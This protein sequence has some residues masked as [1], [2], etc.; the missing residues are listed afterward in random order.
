MNFIKENSMFD[1]GDK[2]IVAF[3]GGPDS[4]CLL[5]ILNELKE[6]WGITLFGAHLNHCLR[7][8]ESDK[9]EEYAKKTCESLNIDFYSKRVD[10]HR[11]SE[12]KNVSCEMAGREERYDFFEELMIKLN[13]SKIALAHNSNDQAET[14]LMRIMRGTGIEGMVGIKPVR[15]RIYVRPILHL[16]RSEIEKYC[17]KND[18]HPRI[19]KSNLE[20]IYARN[21]VRLDLIPYIEENFNSDI[22]NTINRL[23]DILKKD[24]DYLENVSEKEY[25][26][27]CVIGEQMVIIN[28]GAFL[29]HEA[30]VS[31]IIRRALLA[32]NHNLYNF[33]KIHITNIVE[34]QRHDTG[35][36]TMLPQDIIVENCYGNIHIH[37]HKKVTEVNNKEYALKVNEKNI[38]QSLPLNKVIEIDVKSYLQFEE[39]KGNDYIVCFDYDKALEP[40]TFRYRK[41]GDKFMPLGMKG[42]K[43]LKDLFMD[44]KIPKDKR[45]EIPLICFGN[46]IAWVVGYRISEKFKVTK[47]TK[48]ILQIRIGSEE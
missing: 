23:S 30:I 33:E 27:H 3:S 36:T 8:L 34:L 39:V 19:D 9:D 37:I 22:I 1:K 29:Q 44:L 41:Q 32:V 10:I 40:I 43:K 6:E 31:R 14:I 28:K 12:V 20:T 25:K 46:D 5:Y 15:D 7:G 47:N 18:I 26:K 45:N 11:I 42:N 48:N 35:K 21:K 16:S 2:V 13:A 24:N 38:I 4:T 17:E